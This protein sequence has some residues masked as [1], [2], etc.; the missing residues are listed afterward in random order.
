MKTLCVLLL[1]AVAACDSP[2]DKHTVKLYCV[3]LPEQ[4]CCHDFNDR[5]LLEGCDSVSGIKVIINPSNIYTI[6]HRE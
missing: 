2:Q 1:L 4:V 6:E 5:Y 3:D